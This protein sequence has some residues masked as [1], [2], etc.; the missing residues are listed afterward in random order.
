MLEDEVLED[1]PL[2]SFGTFEKIEQEWRPKMPQ[3]TENNMNKNS[4]FEKNLAIENKTSHFIEQENLDDINDLENSELSVNSNEETK[5]FNI[6]IKKEHSTEELVNLVNIIQK[7]IQPNTTRFFI[8]LRDSEVELDNFENTEWV[9]ILSKIKILLSSNT[10]LL[11]T[12]D[13][14]NVVNELDKIKDDQDF[15][16]YIKKVFNNYLH[17]YIVNKEQVKNIQELHRE[18]KSHNFELGVLEPIPIKTYFTNRLEDKP[19]PEQIGKFFG[20]AVQKLMKRG[21]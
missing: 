6:E 14:E 1:N 3:L 10:W 21:K 2:H 4:L 16:E 5:V 15:Q 13:H 20:P 7:N 18:Q 8:K 12:S 17:I 19:L 9:N 11:C